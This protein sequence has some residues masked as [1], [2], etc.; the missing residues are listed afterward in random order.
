[1]TTYL[2]WQEAC[3]I[4]DE[5]EAERKAD[6]ERQQRQEMLAWARRDTEN[7]LG[8]LESLA[9]DWNISY[10]TA[11][12]VDHRTGYSV[13]VDGVSVIEFAD[14]LNDAIVDA[15]LEVLEWEQE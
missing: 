15:Y 7:T 1:M 5:Q 4:L 10:D 2:T 6:E 8:L 13:V 9:Y 12:G 3:K 11:Y 14:N